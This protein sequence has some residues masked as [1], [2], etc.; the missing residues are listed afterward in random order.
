MTL[1]SDIHGIGIFGGTFD[2]IHIGHLRTAVELR[3]VL[4]LHEMRLIT[5]AT[6]PHRIQPQA[7]A[8]HRMAMLHLAL[9]HS[10]ECSEVELIESGSIAPELVADDR[11]LHRKGPSYTLDTL[12][13]IRAEIGTKIPLY[14]CIGMDALVNL[15]QWHRWRELTDVA[16]IVV[17]A[18]PGWH[19]PK[20]GEVLE[21]VR[22][23]RA[24]STEQLQETP[25]GKI[26]IMEMTLLP[27][28]ATGIRQALQRKD[29]IRYLVPDQVIDYIRQHQLYLDN[30]ANPK[31]EIQ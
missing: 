10:S 30:K 4:G 25:A 13:E 26:L 7:S 11:E 3:K 18:R 5:S 21:F 12:T 24:T 6:P 1:T 19:L 29:S 16:H 22:A 9:S 14:L 27:V 28:S 20:S 2:P 8:E 23:H 17:T 31:Q 15:N